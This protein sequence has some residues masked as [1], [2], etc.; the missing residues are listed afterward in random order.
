MIRQRSL[1]LVLTLFLN[2]VTAA[3]AV[4]PGTP[5]ASRFSFNA[6]GS[7]VTDSKTGLVWTRCSVGQTWSGS[8]CAGT[9]A[10]YTHEEALQLAHTASDW[11]L[12]NVK[13]LFSLADKGCQYP[14][15]DGT[16]FPGT[17]VLFYWS[18][19]PGAGVSSHGAWSVAFSLGA[20]GK[21]QRDY[22]GTVRLVR[23]SQ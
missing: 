15:I 10:T 18:S 6:S 5:T 16:A 21:V 20:V 12:P 19:S 2:T 7:E 14:A 13:E 3:Q 22:R 23:V 11:R 9:A 17:A 1:P 4:C 8:A